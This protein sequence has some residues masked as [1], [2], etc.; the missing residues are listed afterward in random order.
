MQNTNLSDK[1]LKKYGKEFKKSLKARK[2]ELDNFVPCIN[3]VID[4]IDFVADS[5]QNFPLCDAVHNLEIMNP[6]MSH[7]FIPMMEDICD[8]TLK[9]LNESDKVYE[10]VMSIHKTIKKM[11]ETIKEGGEVIVPFS[12]AVNIL[13]T[14]NPDIT[15]IIASYLK[16]IGKEFKE[17]LDTTRNNYNLMNL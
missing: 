12:K 6:E 4:Y 8:N 9:Q 7:L 2:A 5:G 15:P 3:D 16:D 10:S 14:I 1:E 13:Q 11:K 17:W